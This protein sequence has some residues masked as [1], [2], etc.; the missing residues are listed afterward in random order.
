MDTQHFKEKL[1]KELQTIEGELKNLGRLDT[2]G[3]KNNW[4]AVEPESEIDS[5]DEGDVADV[6][7]SYE[8]TNSVVENLEVQLK[9]VKSALEKIK[10]GTYGKCEVSGEPIE[11][12]RLEA[13]PAAR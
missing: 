10:N 12:D 5:A 11:A 2:S 3:K 4:E 7:G 9:E 6:I 8:N 13:N 1:E